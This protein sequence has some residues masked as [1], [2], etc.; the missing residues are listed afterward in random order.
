MF[1]CV[2]L[3]E[4]EKLIKN[5]RLLGL[6]VL[7]AEPRELVTGSGFHAAGIQT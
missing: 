6:I 7:Q 4:A 5:K 2:H 3:P 1:R